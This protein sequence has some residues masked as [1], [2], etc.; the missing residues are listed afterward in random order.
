MIEV[1]SLGKRFG[2]VQALQGV[3][4]SARDGRI[5]GLLGPNGAGKSTCLRILYTV[6]KP[7][8]VRS[9]NTIINTSILTPTYRGHLQD[10]T[11]DIEIIRGLTPEGHKHG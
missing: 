5:T 9:L 8:S 1:Q 11:L 10:S 4:F 7:D 2:D 3:S 6:L